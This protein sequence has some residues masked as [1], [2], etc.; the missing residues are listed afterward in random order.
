[1][2]N[3]I[4]KLDIIEHYPDLIDA[5][6]LLGELNELIVGTDSRICGGAVRDIF[7]GIV[8]RD[9]DIITTVDIDT[10]KDHFNCVD[11]GKSADF[12]ITMVEYNDVMYDVKSIEGAIEEDCMNRD[13]SMNA[14]LLDVNGN[15]TDPFGGVLHMQRGLIKPVGFSSNH[16]DKVFQDDPIRM[17][18]LIRFAVDTGLTFELDT[19]ESMCSNIDLLNDVSIERFTLELMKVANM[20]GV[21]MSQFIDTLH[22]YGIL[23]IFIP[24][25]VACEN[26]FHH[27]EHHPEG[28]I[29]SCKNEW[30]GGDPILKPLDIDEY[31]SSDIWE[32]VQLGSVYDHIMECLH[33]IPLSENNPE[34]ILSVLFHDI[35]KPSVAV[36]VENIEQLPASQYY[37]HENVGVP[38]FLD[39]AERLKLNT[40]VKEAVVFCIKQHMNFRRLPE[41][42]SSKAIKICLNP[43][44]DQ[45][46]TVAFCD[47]R[48]RCCPK[49][50]FKSDEFANI[51]AVHDKYIEEYENQVVFNDKVKQFVT[52]DMVMEIRPDLKNKDIGKCLN[53]V[54]CSITDK[55]FDVSK[56]NVIDMIKHYIDI[57]GELCEV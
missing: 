44:F 6:N 36:V 51:L 57:E 47:E 26:Y 1:M 52:G 19:H 28:A 7:M 48:S 49:S 46:V 56:Q 13:F 8:P 37:G 39:I 45:L 10:I 17:V 33:E 25:L 35:G 14:M 21:Q 4:T 23:E 29:M 2:N 53:Y 30:T 54:K 20:G 31:N 43:N 38:I 42:K 55:H 3:E 11:F 41:M 27:W 16:I 22:S 15:V 18:R 40:S 50:L 5:F 9:I 24:E 12:G 32:I 34:S